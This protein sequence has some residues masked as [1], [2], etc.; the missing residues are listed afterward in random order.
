M[1]KAWGKQRSI[2]VGRIG[3]SFMKKMGLHVDLKEWKRF[4]KARSKGK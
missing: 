3:E 4:G 1:V 2:L